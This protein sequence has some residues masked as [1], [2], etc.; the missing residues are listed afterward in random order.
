M[1]A[2]A[3]RHRVDMPIKL[4]GAIGAFAQ[5]DTGRVHLYGV[6]VTKGEL[7]IGPCVDIGKSGE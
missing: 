1:T 2:H 4:L 6:L 3:H 5:Q 7:D